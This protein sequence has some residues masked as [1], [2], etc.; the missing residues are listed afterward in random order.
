MGLISA[1]EPV[2]QVGKR[3]PQKG[4]G[5]LGEVQVARPSADCGGIRQTIGILKRRRGLFPATVLPKATLQC[6]HPRQ[7]A[8]MR[9][10]QRKER[11]EGEGLAATKTVTATD[12]NP[13]VMFIVRLL[14]AA[15]VTDDGIAHTNWALAQDDPVALSRPISFELVER[16][17]KWDKKNRSPLGLCSR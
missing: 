3:L 7:Q 9:V 15:S 17:R 8:V 5:R 1:R 12:P 13:V 16:G 14:T 4:K 10:R 11:K 6:L 2:N